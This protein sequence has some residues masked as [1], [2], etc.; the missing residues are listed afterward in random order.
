MRHEVFGVMFDDLPIETI[1]ERFRTWLRGGE[2]H[3]VVTPNPEFLLQAR[4]DPEFREYLNKSDLVVADGVG[5]RYA[6]AALSDGNLRHRQTG[7]DMLQLLAAVCE[8]QGRTL[9]LLGG[10]PGSAQSA[11]DVFLR[12]FPR[13]RVL[14]RDPG[15]VD[16]ENILPSLLQE[17]SEIRPDVLAVAL[18]QGKQERFIHEALRQLPSVRIAIGVGGAFDM[19]SG[20]R[21]RAP[22]WLRATGLEWL[23]RLIIEPKRAR[24]IARAVILFPIVVAC[25]TL[26]QRRFLRA[27]RRVFPEVFDQLFRR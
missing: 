1:S 14:G 2:A 11:A 21:P 5:I 3:V 26:K 22:R 20:K 16:P 7:V 9:L 6:V 19:I 8:E 24:R 27:C 13:L 17:V 4:R 15:A 10:L 25:A 12:R 23:W 18:G